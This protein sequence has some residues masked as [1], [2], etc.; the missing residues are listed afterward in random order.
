MR[1]ISTLKR[2]KYFA[3]AMVLFLATMPVLP[4][5]K[6]WAEAS[7][8][9]SCLSSTE[10]T[11]T[12]Q[13]D[14]T[15]S[16]LFT[17]D[18]DLTINLNGYKISSSSTAKFFEVKGHTLN[19]V[20]LGSIVTTNTANTGIIRVFG[21][22][23]ADLGS[24][25]VTVDEG[26]TL[27][28][29]NP[30]VVYNNNGTAYNTQVDIYG[31]LNGQNSGIWM[32]GTIANKVN[33]PVVNIHDGAVIS[34]NNTDSSAVSAMGYAEWNIGKATITGTGSGIGIK[35]GIVNIDG[36]IV[37][38]TGN[39]AIL[40]PATY[41]NGINPSGAAIQIEKNSGYA[42]G[43]ELSIS[44]GTFTSDYNDAIYTYGPADG[45]IS[46]IKVSGGT[47][48]DPNMLPTEIEAGKVIYKVG[49]NYVVDDA[50]SYELPAR[51]MMEA[52]TYTFDGLKDDVIAQKYGKVEAHYHDYSSPAPVFDKAAG[53]LTSN[54]EVYGAANLTYDIYESVGGVVT[55]TDK[56]NQKVVFDTY[57][58]SKV[59]P[60]YVKMGTPITNFVI[61]SKMS[62]YGN[63]EFTSMVVS[64]EDE[65]VAT[66]SK[67]EDGTYTLTGVKTGNTKI[68]ATIT[69]VDANIEPQV[70][71][72]GTVYVWDLKTENFVDNYD[73][74]NLVTKTPIFK[75]Y[76][77]GGSISTV[78][79]DASGN[80]VSDIIVQRD[81]TTGRF[82]LKGDKNTRPGLYKVE[83]IDTV[84]G[85]E[86]D[87]LTTTVRVHSINITGSPEHYIVI[88]RDPSHQDQNRLNL[89]VVEEN[90]FTEN[91][92]ITAS[93]GGLPVD[94][95]TPSYQHLGN[96]R[97]TG[98]EAGAYTVTF[99]DGYAAARFKVFVMKFTFGQDSYHVRLAED[100]PYIAV[101]AFNQYWHD[102]NAA[103]HRLDTYFKV[104][105]D[106]G[107]IDV[108]NGYVSMKMD[109]A[110]SEQGEDYRFYWCE[111]DDNCLS[112][113][114]YTI[115][116]SAD[117]NGGSV[118][119]NG[120][121]ATK[122]V[123]LHIYN[124]VAPDYGT[125]YTKVNDTIDVDVH[126]ENDRG[127]V[128]ATIEA[129][130]GDADGLSF[131]T[132]GF[133]PWATT[134]Y[135]RLE[136]NKP[137]VYMVHYTDRMANGEIVGTYDLRV[138][139][140]E[141]EE[142]TLL[143]AEGETIDI[144]GSADWD[145]SYAVDATS[146]EEYTAED[147]VIKFDTTGMELGRHEVSV[148][149][150]F[151]EYEEEGYP[152]ARE[153]VKKVNVVVY[154]IDSDPVSDPEGVTG[155]TVKDLFDALNEEGLAD[156]LLESSF[157][158]LWNIADRED[159]KALFG[160][161]HTETFNALRSLRDAI[162]E[163]QKVSTF[164]DVR[165]LTEEEVETLV[166]E[167]L[168][169]LVKVMDSEGNATYYDVNIFMVVNEEILGM[170]HQLNSPITVCLGKVE[171][172]ADG[173]SRQFTV[174]RQHAGET[175]EV[176]TEGLK[177]DGGF[178]VEDGKL[179]IVSSKFSQYAMFYEDTLNPIPPKA[180]DTGNEAKVDGTATVMSLG[181]TMLLV[182]SLMTLAGSVVAAKRK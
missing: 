37:K 56:Y 72:L 106:E 53:T 78:V 161:S 131:A 63:N 71:E 40:P 74:G 16:D 104:V 121:T 135:T 145:A 180:P 122:N 130:S 178:F 163:G 125:R 93:V 114:N 69:D 80:P 127:D 168:K 160:P 91:R 43:V 167:Q 20:G 176:M 21:T 25:R 173:Y 85:E 138:V 100:E 141:V 3:A 1:L 45:A 47:F 165:E 62:R 58:V 89:N 29:P 33:Y 146:G 162:L 124:M 35:A 116:Y 27:S 13:G 31:T 111:D 32:I 166:D 65:S 118:A 36:A 157:W 128:T 97:L 101:N 140:I 49:S 164:V 175:P 64:T 76:D 142:Q 48:S 55:P 139:V 96:W 126:D 24:T 120:K 148:A 103:E 147:G 137:G 105:K 156:D 171:G 149:H 52:G 92:D 4:I 15:M 87:R 117:A 50:P 84:G 38:G 113:G 112:A 174:I 99:S 2:A 75:V 90:G 9:A 94:G 88:T 83:F 134:D 77:E 7:T 26:V 19:I 129:I 17:L 28:G 115:H 60:Q 107:N 172:P 144:T 67:N 70:V 98:N 123:R 59:G 181:V 179:Y 158:R 44:S 68:L 170:M 86:V 169:D 11:C 152:V 119:A 102:I 79:K 150:D 46:S 12:L 54:R 34:A 14:E 155:D 108:T 51:I 182:L 61:N 81:D 136:A 39:P 110:V 42:G 132:S 57:S 154:K 66:I 82:R 8:L 10:N 5:R 41:N 151:E 153:T 177:A 95:L 133:G 30:I 22:D 143:V 73:L 18:R 109:P 23:T 6:A 159:A